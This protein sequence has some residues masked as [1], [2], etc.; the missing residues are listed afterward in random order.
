MSRAYFPILALLGLCALTLPARA[1]IYKWVDATGQVHLADRKLGP[2]YRLIMRTPRSRP[3]APR[4][5]S[6]P[7]S[8]TSAVPPKQ[9]RFAKLI[10]RAAHAYR[11]DTALVHAVISAES[12]YDPDAVSSKG[13]A[14]LMQLMPATA[15]RYGASNRFNPV[16]NVYAGVRYLNDL[17]NRFNSLVLALAAYNAGENAVEKYGNQVPPYPETREYVRRVLTYYRDYRHVH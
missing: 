10:R 1:D 3:P 4:A 9:A 2:G 16:Q 15:Y 11:I 14:G 8:S 17:L 12:S 5:S 6:P 7:A 13:A